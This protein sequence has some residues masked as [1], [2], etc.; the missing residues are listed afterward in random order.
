MNLGLIITSIISELAIGI[1][2]E[3]VA[4]CRAGWHY[5]QVSSFLP[6]LVL[7]LGV[8]FLCLFVFVHDTTSRKAG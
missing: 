1:I 7:G 8:W 6:F 3:F 2:S 4:L 5:V